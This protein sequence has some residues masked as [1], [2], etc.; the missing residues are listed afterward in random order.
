MSANELLTELTGQPACNSATEG[1]RLRVRAPEGVLTTELR[2]RLA[3]HKEALLSRCWE[4]RLRRAMRAAP[5]DRGSGSRYEP[6]PLTDIQQ[7]YWIG[8]SGAYSLGQVS[9]HAYFEF[10]GQGLDLG[11]L[12]GPG[13]PRRASRHASRRDARRRPAA[14][15]Q[16]C[17]PTRSEC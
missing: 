16:S 5:G 1:D 4:R 3:E 11:R 8:R 10:D 13:T 14:V 15:L 2:G 6:F 7:A 12:G 17:P 9:C